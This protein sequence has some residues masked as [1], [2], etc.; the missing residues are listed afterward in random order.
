MAERSYYD[1]PT[2]PPEV[3]AQMA[4]ALYS[5]FYVNAMPRAAFDKAIAA[6]SD[7]DIA[8]STFETFYKGRMERPA[9]N[10]M[11]NLTT[12]PG[13]TTGAITSGATLGL[14]DEVSGAVSG[15]ASMLR[16]EGFGVGYDRTTRGMRENAAVFRQNNPYLGSALEI[17]GA[18]P[19]GAPRMGA[20]LLSQGRS[21]VPALAHPLLTTSAQGAGMGGVAGAGDAEGGV[22]NRLLGAGQGALIGAAIPPVVAGAASAAGPLARGIGNILGWGN[23]VQQAERKVGRALERGRDRHA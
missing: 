12:A 4:D 17:A 11:L 15:L 5:K 18:V 14:A 1:A 23:P 8:N 20:A 13:S 22:M 10:K 21:S 16:G 7:L 9:F 6:Q 19:M 3:R 2:L